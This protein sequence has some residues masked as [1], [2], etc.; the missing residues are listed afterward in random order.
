[1]RKA[2]G[3]CGAA[4]AHASPRL[5]ADPA[6]VLAAV[7]QDGRALRFAAPALREDVDLVVKARSWR[8]RPSDSSPQMMN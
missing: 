4:L 2:V 1:M 5:R 8:G 7:G 3:L 6:V